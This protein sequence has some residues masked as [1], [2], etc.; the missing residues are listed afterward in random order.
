MSNESATQKG[1]S[2]AAQA[3]EFVIG[4]DLRVTRRAQAHDSSESFLP[5]IANGL[6]LSLISPKAR[7]LKTDCWLLTAS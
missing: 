7:V 5:C 2:L 3:G 1:S 4:N 6:S